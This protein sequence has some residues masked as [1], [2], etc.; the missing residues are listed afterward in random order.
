VRR[1]ELGPDVATDDFPRPGERIEL[2]LFDDVTIAAVVKSSSTNVNGTEVGSCAVEGSRF[3]TIYMARTQGQMMAVVNIPER[4]AQYRVL[5]DVASAQHFAVEMDMAKLLQDDAGEHPVAPLDAPKVP[6]Y[7]KLLPA[8]VAAKVLETP[9]NS[10]TLEG[11]V[12]A[13]DEPVVGGGGGGGVAAEDPPEEITIDIMF[14][15]TP[16]AVTEA[17]NLANL[18]DAMAIAVT[19]SNDAHSNTDTGVAFRLVH[20]VQTEYTESGDESLSDELT[21]VTDTSDG[22]MDEIHA[23]RDSYKADFVQLI[24]NENGGGGIAWELNASG[25]SPSYGFSAANYASLTGVLTPAHEMGHNMGCGHA[26]DQT[27]QPGP[28][29]ESDAG[30]WHW[31]PTAGASGY[32]TVMA[33]TSGSYY[34]DGLGHT[35]L[36]YFSDPTIMLDGYAAGDATDANNAR[37]IRTL[38]RIYAEYRSGDNFL[39]VINNNNGLFVR[40]TVSTVL[41]NSDLQTSDANGFDTPS[42]LVYTIATAP[43]KGTLK[44]D[45]TALGATSTFTQEDIDSGSI[46]YTSA[47][48]QTGTDSLV[49]HVKDSQSAGS[50]DNSFLITIDST[51]PTATTFS[52]YAGFG[53]AGINANPSITFNENIIAGS[54]GN[55]LI[56]QLSDDSL[57]E[58]IAVTSSQVTISGTTATVDPSVTF[59][60]NTGYYIEI[61]DAGTFKDKAG[62][63]FAGF[64]GSSTW[65]FTTSTD[66]ASLGISA[67]SGPKYSNTPFS[68]TLTAKKADGTTDTT[69]TGTGKRAALTLYHGES[70][71]LGSGTSSTSNFPFKVTAQEQRSEVIYLQSEVGAATTLYGISLNVKTLPNPAL[72]TSFTVRLAHT[73]ETAFTVANVDNASLQ[74]CYRGDYTIAATGWID[75]PFATPFSYNGTD[76]LIVSLSYDNGSNGTTNGSLYVYAPGGTRTLYKS[77]TSSTGDPTG[78]T[79]LVTGSTNV[80]QIKLKK[81]GSTIGISPAE[82]GDFTN[83]VWTGN[84]TPQATSSG[85]VLFAE[86]AEKRGDSDLFVIDAGVQITEQPQAQ[87]I[88][89]G[90]TAGLSVTATGTSLTYQWY[91]GSSGSGTQID[92]ATSSSYTTPAL[93]TTTQYWVRVSGGSGSVDSD[94]ATVTVNGFNT[95]ATNKSLTGSDALATAD[96]DD[97]GVSNLIEYALNA[98]PT[99]ADPATLPVVGVEGSN[100]TLTYRKNKN[101]PDITFLVQSSTDLVLWTDESEGTKQSDIDAGTESWKFDK[102]LGGNTKL[103]LRLKITQ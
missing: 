3:G 31:H 50:N 93:T 90:Q 72:L 12:M 56:R 52:P 88:N 61:P 89:S 34:A 69:F 15:Y 35:R 46:T 30:G 33:Y 62:N 94:T 92:G 82:T 102:A 54:S 2:H 18:Q 6:N 9:P 99:A 10:R 63:D 58:T 49:F 60:Y 65:Y 36:P 53:A 14:V 70:Q 96:P 77:E 76:N 32:C 91:Q 100:V 47:A 27:S 40:P 97:D 42:L 44:K 73:T 29:I 55:I 84:V 103:F 71:T 25:G 68:V 101:A 37:I 4:N 78:W 74:T 86:I 21:R 57:V 13:E 28:G 51:P 45:A 38:K 81:R 41:T 75:I 48:G 23:I 24:C 11:V 19:E 26:K 5:F 79:T 66:L 64:S 1:V 98:D 39:P 8:S 85:A 59:A 67:I 16:A 95:W 87:T 17:G 43:A 22:F 80:P 7:E 83:G 20:S